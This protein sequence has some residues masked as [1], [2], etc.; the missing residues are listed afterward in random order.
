M[1]RLERTVAAA[2]NWFNYVACAAVVVMMLLSCADV[3]LRLVSSP[4][5]GTYEMVGLLGAV[6]IAFAMAYTSLQRGHVAVEMIYEKLPPRTQIVID[7]AGSLIGAALFGMIAWQSAVYGI[8]LR[9]SGEVSLTLQMP[10]YPIVYGIALGCGLLALVLLMDLI[11]SFK[12]G[13]SS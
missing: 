13:L 6:I 9:Q 7:S 1:L 4:I 2:S 11:K 12:K 8:D 3:F 5:P 10:L